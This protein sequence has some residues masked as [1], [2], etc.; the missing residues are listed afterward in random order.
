MNT[1]EAQQANTTMCEKHNIEMK[2]DLIPMP[3]GCPAIV[4]LHCPQCEEEAEKAEQERILFALKKTEEELLCKGIPKKFRN[5]EISDFEN[6][7]P[8]LDWLKNP[9]G[10]LFVFG[11]CGCGKSH[12]AS[13]VKKVFNTK[14]IQS[15]MFFSSDIFLTIRNT[16]NKKDDQE[17]ELSVV[18]KYAPDPYKGNERNEMKEY[19][20]I[21]IFDD[22]GA[23]KVS[24]YVIEAWY[25][26]IDRRYMHEHPTMFTSNLSLKEMSLCMTDRIASRLASGVVF[27]L[28]GADRRITNKP[29]QA[30][31]LQ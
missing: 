18:K 16:F 19:S 6:I 22:I 14:S 29:K 13:A 25:N 7:K 27:E 3:F 11:S 17:T 9:T 5:A 12:L 20:H 10:F 28:K 30:Q 2:K 1:K 31:F 8:V 4:N 24:D 23:Q 26:I 21:A 15:D